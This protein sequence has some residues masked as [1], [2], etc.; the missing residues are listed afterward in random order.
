MVWNHEA[1]Q[2]L[3]N[4]EFDGSRNEA[5]FTL[6]LLFY[7]MGKTESECSQFLRNEWYPGFPQR[8]EP[9][10]LSALSASIRSAYS[11]KYHGPSKEKVEALTDVPF[12]LKIYKG[13]YI[14]EEK[15][16]KK[17]NRQ[18]IINYFRQHGGT[19]E[20]VQTELIKDICKTQSSPIG[21]PYAESSIKRNL[22]QLRKEGVIHWETV[23]SGRNTSNKIL[24]TFNEGIQAE[25]Q[26]VIEPDYNVYVLG[27]AVSLH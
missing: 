23:R 15:H 14:R 17:E 22:L 16:N 7:A 8:G 5:G 21:K 18:A 1:I 3:M 27:Q 4:G 10:H 2:N 12:N 9:Y 11:G 26:T 6:A 20:M 19:V 25:S 24:F 13:T